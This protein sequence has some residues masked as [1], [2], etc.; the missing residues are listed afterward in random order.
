MGII[1]R[2]QSWRQ[3]IKQRIC[4]DDFQ[5]SG[6]WVRTDTVRE[7]SRCEITTHSGSAQRVVFESQKG[8]KTGYLHAHAQPG[9]DINV[10][11]SDWCRNVFVTG[12]GGAQ[13]EF[14][15]EPNSTPGQEHMTIDIYKSNN[16][17]GS[18]I[19]DDDIPN[20]ATHLGTLEV[21]I[22]LN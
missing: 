8:R 21:D 10:T 5:K 4:A 6:F 19:P 17:M 22:N 1:K 12:R 18:S 3:R 2:I 11:S 15:M 20:H 9:P 7:S 16:I 13:C 14:D